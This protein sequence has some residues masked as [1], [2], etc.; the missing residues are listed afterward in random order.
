MS[1]FFYFV[2]FILSFFLSFVSFSIDNTQLCLLF[3]LVHDLFLDNL[4]LFFREKMLIKTIDSHCIPHVY[5]NLFQCGI[6][7]AHFSHLVSGL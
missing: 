4:L 1:I 3:I 2:F 5:L 6:A 7:S